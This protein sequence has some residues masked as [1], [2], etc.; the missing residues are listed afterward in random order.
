MG[1]ECWLKCGLFLLAKICPGLN[2][3]SLKKF[4]ANFQFFYWQH[5]RGRLTD[6]LCRYK[7]NLQGRIRGGKSCRHLI[8]VQ[9]KDEEGPNRAGTK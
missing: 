7:I 2:V 9:G 6:K 8:N 1:S 4:T 5:C 3:A